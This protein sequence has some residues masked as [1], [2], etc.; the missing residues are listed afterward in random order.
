M[1]AIHFANGMQP[2]LEEHEGCMNGNGEAL[3]NYPNAVK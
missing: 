1:F 2:S 3:S